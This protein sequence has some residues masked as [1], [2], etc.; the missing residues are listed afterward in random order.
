MGAQET[1]RY[2]YI[3]KEMF[4]WIVQNLFR[5]QVEDFGQV[6]FKQKMIISAYNVRIFIPL[7]KILPSERIMTFLLEVLKSSNL[8]PFWH[9][10]LLSLLSEQLTSTVSKWLSE[11]SVLPRSECFRTRLYRADHNTENTT[12]FSTS[13]CFASASLA[14]DFIPSQ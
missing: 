10:I 8:P 5:R 7:E 14:R 6:V 12:P 1:I 3:F 2:A 11:W 9:S 13:F 4:A